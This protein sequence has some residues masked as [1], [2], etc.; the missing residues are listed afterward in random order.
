MDNLKHFG[1]EYQTKWI[2]PLD[3]VKLA[4]ICFLDDFALASTSFADIFLVSI[5]N[6]KC[7]MKVPYLKHFMNDEHPPSAIFFEYITGMESLTLD[8]FTQQRMDNFIHGIRQIHKT[9]VIHND[10]KPRNMMV[11]KNT[12]SPGSSIPDSDRVLWLDFDRAQTYNEGEITD[13]QMKWIEEEEQI[14]LQLA[15]ALRSTGKRERELKDAYLF[16]CT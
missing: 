4:D 16:Y 3:N 15:S 1:L 9:L 13:Q 6:Q 11:I 12:S 2:L 7:I 5:R 8:N 10:T 14:V